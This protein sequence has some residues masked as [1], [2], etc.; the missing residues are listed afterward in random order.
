MKLEMLETIIKLALERSP[1]NPDKASK[2]IAPYVVKLLDVISRRHY[3]RKNKG[4]RFKDINFI[5]IN[6][7]IMN[8][9]GDAG[10]TTANVEDELS[11][12]IEAFYERTE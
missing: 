3:Q 9:S 4:F 12:Q 8:S 2:E 7:I 6:Q 5:K 11:T 10:M 1:K